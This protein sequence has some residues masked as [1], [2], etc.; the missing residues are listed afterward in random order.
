MFVES[1]LSTWQDIANLSMNKRTSW[2][3][4]NLSELV[5]KELEWIVHDYT[6]VA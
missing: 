3:I 2:K 1:Q 6:M 5:S 4:E